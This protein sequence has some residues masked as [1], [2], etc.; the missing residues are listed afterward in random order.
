MN[1]EEKVA[2][3][4]DISKKISDDN[5]GLEESLSLYRQG[6]EL[7]KE[8]LE[9]LNENKLKVKEISNEMAMLFEEK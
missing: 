4:E 9:I 2:Q 3:L 7:A 5:V 6:V 8:C 1:F